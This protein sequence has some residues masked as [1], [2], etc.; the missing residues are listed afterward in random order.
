MN[1]LKKYKRKFKKILIH[2]H[3]QQIAQ[4]VHQVQVIQKILALVLRRSLLNK[5]QILIRS[6]IHKNKV[7]MKKLVWTHQDLFTS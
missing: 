7:Q 6:Q 2:H 3:H 5:I 1:N 4:I